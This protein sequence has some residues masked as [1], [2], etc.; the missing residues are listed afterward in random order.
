MIHFPGA[1]HVGLLW[2]RLRVELS[3]LQ[4]LGFA[5]RQVFELLSLPPWLPPSL[6]LPLRAGPIL[7]CGVCLRAGIL[8][9]CWKLVISL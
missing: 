1:S 6:A 8:A 4:N 7:S 5:R 3:N 9:V 2:M